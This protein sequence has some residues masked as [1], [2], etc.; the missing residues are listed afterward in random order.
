V[1]WIRRRLIALAVALLARLGY[2]FRPLADAG[3]ALPV[4]VPL[5][6]SGAAWLPLR[7]LGLPGEYTP[8]TGGEP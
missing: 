6:A 5:C 1:T 7:P 8:Q 2:P 4:V 3:P